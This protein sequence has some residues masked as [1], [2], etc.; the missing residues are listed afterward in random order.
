M[1]AGYYTAL[2][3]TL[4]FEHASERHLE[5]WQ[6]NV[7]VHKHGLELIKPGVRCCDIAKELNEIFLKHN[8][9]FYQYYLYKFL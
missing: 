7:E 2:E 4:F 5:I 8:F 9:F 6:A 3:R 1:I